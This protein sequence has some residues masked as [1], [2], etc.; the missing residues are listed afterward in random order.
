MLLNNHIS[1]PSPAEKTSNHPSFIIP[2]NQIIFIDEDL[3]IS[4][5]FPEQI[6]TDPIYSNE[7]LNEAS[8]TE[9]TLVKKDNVLVVETPHQFS[10]PL[11]FN[12]LQSELLTSF[13]EPNADVSN[14]VSLCS[15]V[16][17]EEALTKEII[18]E[19]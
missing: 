8:T 2:H 16:T 6:I 1:V 11:Q 13:Q 12:A 15:D 10:S 18:H 7:P 5:T 9:P 4:S 19:K 3:A 14:K 17:L